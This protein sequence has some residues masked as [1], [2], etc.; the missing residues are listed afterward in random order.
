M[1]GLPEENRQRKNVAMTDAPYLDRMV[2][3]FYKE[4]ELN[5]RTLDCG[6]ADLRAAFAKVA[7]VYYE[8]GRHWDAGPDRKM[9]EQLRREA[10]NG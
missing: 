2:E 4:W 7:L 5:D 10:N 9:L 3:E 6:K 8:K 1:C